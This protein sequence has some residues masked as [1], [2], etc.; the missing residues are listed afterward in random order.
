MSVLIR[1][2]DYNENENASAVKITNFEGFDILKKNLMSSQTLVLMLDLS[3]LFYICTMFH[4]GSKISSGLGVE[5]HE[6][7]IG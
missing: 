7:W 3:Q 4:V 6:W 5:S 2:Y 1:L